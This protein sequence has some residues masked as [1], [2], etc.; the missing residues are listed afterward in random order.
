MEYFTTKREGDVLTVYLKDRLDTQTSPIVQEALTPMLDGVNHLRLDMAQ[1]NYMS[2]A[3]LRTLLFLLQKMEDGKGDMALSNVNEVIRDVL[4]ITA[5]NE[6][7][8]I[9]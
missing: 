1:L 5:M 8:T 4:E 6:I 7:L 9:E 2:S 3:G